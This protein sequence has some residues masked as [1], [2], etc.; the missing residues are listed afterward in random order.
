MGIMQRNEP[1]PD[2]I[3]DEEMS[4]L[5]SQS[6]NPE[7]REAI[8]G[9][10]QDKTGVQVRAYRKVAA[11][12]RAEC[13]AL[14]SVRELEIQRG[15]SRTVADALARAEGAER[16]AHAAEVERDQKQAELNRAIGSSA[17]VVYGE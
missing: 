17:A 15:E 16:R 13:D 8:A 9:Q 5:R 2:E 10:R 1:D 3:T 14:L 4:F 6:V 11:L 12:A 7:I